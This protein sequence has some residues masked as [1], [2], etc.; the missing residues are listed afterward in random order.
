MRRSA[1]N[2]ALFCA[3][4]SSA[5]G[6]Q[7]PHS[8]LQGTAVWPGGFWAVP[9]GSSCTEAAAGDCCAHPEPTHAGGRGV[10]GHHC[11]H[12]AA[13]PRS[14]AQVIVFLF[15]FVFGR[16]LQSL[17]PPAGQDCILS[18]GLKLLC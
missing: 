14:P 18:Y 2:T 1:I 7:E 9:C 10:W 5:R 3:T 11:W 13:H 4:Y 17:E 12:C 8:A 16:P 15:S 6:D